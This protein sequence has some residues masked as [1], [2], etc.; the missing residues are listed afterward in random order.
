MSAS[1]CAKGSTSKTHPPYSDMVNHALVATKSKGGSMTC[2][3]KY[4]ADTYH[5]DSDKTKPYI[6]RCVKRGLESGTLVQ[7]KGQGTGGSFRLC[8]KTMRSMSGVKSKASPKK[9]S[10]LKAK[11]K[12]ASPKKAKKPA[13]KSPKKKLQKST[14]RKS[15]SKG[16]RASTGAAK[17]RKPAA[18]KAKKVVKKSPAKKARR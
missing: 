5:V 17:K 13:R 14:G 6:K 15:T 7:T 2:I 8:A 4:I 11:P 16:S 3:R 10:K 9:A 1:R 18:S 12:K